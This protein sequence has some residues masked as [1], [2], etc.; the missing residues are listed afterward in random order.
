MRGMDSLVA[1]RSARKKPRTVFVALVPRHLETAGL[2]CWANLSIEVVP[3]DAIDRLDLR[4]LVGCKVAVFDHADDP[5][6]HL[7]L[8]DAVARVRPAS[9][10]TVFADGEEYTMHRR[11]AP[12]YHTETVR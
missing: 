9:V 2:D 12:D 6:R 1:L 10:W 3:E 8:F 11:S 4:P 7:D 5:E